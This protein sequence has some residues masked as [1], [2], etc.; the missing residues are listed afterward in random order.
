M[1]RQKIDKTH[2][3]H[4]HMLRVRVWVI[5]IMCMLV[6]AYFVYMLT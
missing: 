3:H 4:P 5:V 6:V 2:P 1:A